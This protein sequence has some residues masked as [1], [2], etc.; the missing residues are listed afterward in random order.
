M[1]ISGYFLPTVKEDPSDAEIA[2]HRL[3]IRAG[4]IRKLA[5][6]IYSYLPLGLRVLRKVENIVRE[7]MNRAG[8]VETLLPSMI[9]A[10][11]WKET[12]RWELYGKELLRIKDRH[13]N[14]FC[15]GPTHEEVMTDLVRRDVR[16]YKD[17]P[18][19]LYQIQT[20]FRDEIRPRFGLMRGREFI[21]K[22]AYSFDRDEESAEKSYRRMFAAYESV[23]ARSGLTFRAVEADTGAIGGTSSHEFMVLASSGEDLIVSC[24]ACGY[25]SNI[26]KAEVRSIPPAAKDAGEAQMEKVET[27]GKRT[28]EEVSEFLK[29]E[30]SEFI[31]TL[32]YTTDGGEDCVVLVRGDFDV[33]ETK[34]AR[35]L[36]AGEVQLATEEKVK[37]LTGAS[38]GFAGPVGLECKIIADN[39]IKGIA[40][41]VTGADM[42]DYHLVGVAEGRDFKVDKFGD[43]RNAREGDPCPRCDEGEVEFHRGIEVGHV[44][45]LGVKYS[46]AMKAT[47]LDA[48]GREKVIVMGTYGIG[49]ARI[50]AAAIEQSHDEKGIVW[51]WAIAPF[52]VALLPLNVR[53]EHVLDTAARLEKELENDGYEVLLD[54]RDERAGFKFN[55]AD[56]IGI[57]VQVIV[58]EK[59]L[60][61]GEVEIKVRKTGERLNVKIDDL[62][63]TLNKIVS[64]LT[65]S[66]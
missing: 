6:G 18:L 59:G 40:D 43:L 38:V 22:D 44:F 7:E 39:S 29:R 25:A 48:D 50:A 32:V 37:E 15:Y 65:A 62:K 60:K 13:E 5:S 11:L 63:P 9:P 23:F 10:E 36:G 49:I 34:V 27:P 56:L 47:F 42:D 45:R 58:G 1:K 54:D 66:S 57:P 8:A 52:N 16:S 12:G 26:E 17:L 35:L 46:D 28:I 24:P 30:A 61:N 21:M 31:K 51:P 64:S 33:N 19:T 41:A 4:M 20:K 2:S 53:K 55:D 14:D 3:M